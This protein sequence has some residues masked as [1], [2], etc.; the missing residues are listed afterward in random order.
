MIQGK[1]MD[2]MRP[3]QRN[4]LAYSVCNWSNS[5]LPLPHPALLCAP[6]SDGSV[7]F[8]KFASEIASEAS[9]DPEDS[10]VSS[11]SGDVDQFGPNED[12]KE[13]TTRPAIKA[14]ETNDQQTTFPDSQTCCPITAGLNWSKCYRQTRDK[15]HV[16]HDVGFEVSNVFQPNFSWLRTSTLRTSL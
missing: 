9:R 7:Q 14:L 10:I 12:C 6:W 8:G 2:G 16:V 15:I 3:I 5:L 11:K 4:L 13:T 1:G